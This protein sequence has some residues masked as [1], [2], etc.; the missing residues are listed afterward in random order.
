[1]KQSGTHKTLGAMLLASGATLAI[2]IVGGEVFQVLKGTE[3]RPVATAPAS[4]ATS[5]LTQAFS[6]Q[7]QRQNGYS[8]NS[9]NSES[10]RNSRPQQ[11]SNMTSGQARQV[12]YVA[13]SNVVVGANLNRPA[14]GSHK[15]HSYQVTNYPAIQHSNLPTPDQSQAGQLQTNPDPPIAPQRATPDYPPSQKLVAQADS[16]SHV[17]L[18]E[19][20][21]MTGTPTPATRPANGAAEM[22]VLTHVDPAPTSVNEE[23]DRATSVLQTSFETRIEKP[24]SSV[25]APHLASPIQ[26]DKQGFITKEVTIKN[27]TFEATLDETPTELMLEPTAQATPNVRSVQPTTMP[28]Q[29]VNPQVDSRARERIKYGDSLARRRSFYAAREE[30]IL[31]LLLISNS[32]GDESTNNAHAERLA[33]ALTAIDEVEDFTSMRNRNGRDPQFQQT[34][35]SHKTQLLA[36]TDLSMTSPRKAIDLYCGY[37]QSQIEQAIGFSAAG[38]EALHALGKLE[39]MAPNTSPQHSTTSQTRALVFFRAALSVNGSNALCSNDLGVLLHNMGRLDEA[40]ESLRHSLGSNQSRLVWTNLASV[41]NQQASTAT[42]PD[43]RNQQIRLAQMAEREAQ[44][45]QD[46]P[47]QRGLADTEWATTNDFQNK[48]AI[49]DTVVQ[50][51]STGDMQT[52]QPSGARVKAV[53]FLQKVTGWN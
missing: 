16:R 49:P 4:E 15:N 48:A 39:L 52:Q 38:S 51:A 34:V 17:I 6:T 44:K 41:H 30:F 43:Q 40:E 50:R 5:F 19:P 25:S 2:V 1:M 35:R 22:S 3:F 21:P 9:G 36:G 27:H 18:S 24:S 53:S 8:A 42:T 47:R 46:D 12:S 31:S 23:S 37:A 33:Q 14:T 11:A 13:D 45:F 7:S 32:H 10:G 20:T 28:R 26:A 29:R